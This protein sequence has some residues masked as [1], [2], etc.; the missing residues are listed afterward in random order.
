MMQEIHINGLRLSCHVGVPDEE[1]AHPQEL[2]I[3]LVLVPANDWSRLNDD[4]ENTID[5][6]KVA[7]QMETL[8][9]ERPRKL[10]E[11][12]AVE[13]ADFLLANWPLQQ[14][15]VL[16]DKKILPQTRSVAVKIV[17]QAR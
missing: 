5:Y 6:A 8:A 12:L 2:S 13:M 14:V 16:V 1:R 9:A 7:A 3:D 17:R 15:S 11:T 10:I 4:I